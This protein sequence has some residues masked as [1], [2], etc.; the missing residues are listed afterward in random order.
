M[1]RTQGMTQGLVACPGSPGWEGRQPSTRWGAGPR[2]LTGRGSDSFRWSCVCR[3][4]RRGWL[5]VLFQRRDL[6]TWVAGSPDGPGPR[7]N[8]GLTHLR[9]TRCC[10]CRLGGPGGQTS[11]IEDESE[12]LIDGVDLVDCGHSSSGDDAFGGDDPNLV[13][14]CV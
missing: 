7:S 2:R 12:G 10:P 8:G 11:Q 6:T 13:A 4:L 9:I 1:P 5:S 14:A 3:K